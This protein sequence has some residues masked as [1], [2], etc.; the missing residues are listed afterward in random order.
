R[1]ISKPVLPSCFTLSGIV[2]PGDRTSELIPGGLGGPPEL[3][4]ASTRTSFFQ[5]YR[6]STSWRYGS[7]NLLLLLG[8]A[9]ILVGGSAPWGV[10]AAA[11]ILGSFADEVGGDDRKTVS[12]DRCLF[13]K[14]NLYM[15]L[16]LVCLLALVILRFAATQPHL[17]KHP[18][19]LIGV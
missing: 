18:F 16:P 12:Y 17:T 9:S 5:R 6:L 14:V 1:H 7:A 8:S 19:Q 3:E 10:L 2:V 11:M 15:S 4:L 13:C